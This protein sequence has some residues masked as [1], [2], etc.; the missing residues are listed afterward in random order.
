MAKT[1]K[2]NGRDYTKYFTHRNWTLN[3]EPVIGNNSGVMLDGSYIEDEKKVNAVITISL[4]PLNEA[5]SS[6]I[7]TEVYS[8]AHPV[9][10]YFDLR[11]GRYREI[12]TTRR[13]TPA[14][15]WGGCYGGDYWGNMTITF[16]EAD[17]DANDKE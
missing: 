2:I 17:K 9:L 15:Y 12:K 5:Q 4:M 8:T 3:Y 7:L 13:M 10:Y 16:T 14:T 1:F 11:Q 6:A